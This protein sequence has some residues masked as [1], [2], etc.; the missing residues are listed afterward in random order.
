VLAGSWLWLYLALINQPKLYAATGVQATGSLTAAVLC[1]AVLTFLAT[2]VAA[3]GRWLISLAFFC[4]ITGEVY[5]LCAAGISARHRSP[6]W[7]KG[8]FFS[9]D[10]NPLESG[11]IH[12]VIP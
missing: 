2:L 8:I 1:W 7:V 11:L 12:Y 10:Y 5:C 6:A 9:A 4:L 3:I